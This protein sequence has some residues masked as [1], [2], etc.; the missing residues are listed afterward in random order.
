MLGSPGLHRA[1]TVIQVQRAYASRGEEEEEVFRQIEISCAVTWRSEDLM[2]WIR[3]KPFNHCLARGW[4]KEVAA[5]S[6]QSVPGTSGFSSRMEAQKERKMEAMLCI[7]CC[8]CWI[9]I[10]ISITVLALNTRDIEC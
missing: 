9:G 1:S 7:C 10:T 6:G 8:I 2:I 4:P 5:G 3:R